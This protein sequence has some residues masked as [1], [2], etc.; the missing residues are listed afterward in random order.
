MNKNVKVMEDGSFVSKNK[1][2]T[3]KPWHH[4]GYYLATFYTMG[5]RI[6]TEAYKSY[7]MAYSAVMAHFV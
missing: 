4:E 6:C 2:A 3:I 1:T 5:K 7:D